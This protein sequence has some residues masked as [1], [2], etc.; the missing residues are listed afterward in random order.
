MGASTVNAAQMA[1]YYRSSGKTFPADIYASKGA[2]NIDE[3]CKIVVEEATAEGVRAE[4]LFAQICLETGFLQFGGDVQASDSVRCGDVQGNTVSL[5]RTWSNRW[6][7]CR[8]CISGCK[9]RN[10]CAG[11]APEG[12]CKHRTVKTDLCG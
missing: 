11:T 6:R 12:L 3:F 9:N 1:A 4:V 8:K 5:W 10:P 2:A 7:S